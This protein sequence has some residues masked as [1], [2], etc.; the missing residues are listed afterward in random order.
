MRSRMLTSFLTANIVEP[1]AA[2]NTQGEDA[3]M[4]NIAGE[5]PL[6]MQKYLPDKNL[7]FSGVSLDISSCCYPIMCFHLRSHIDV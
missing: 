7:A 3:S 4:P 6:L 2:H 1:R 5:S